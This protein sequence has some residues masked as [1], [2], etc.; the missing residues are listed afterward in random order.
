M[1]KIHDNINKQPLL[2]NISAVILKE[3]NINTTPT[4]TRTFYPNQTGFDTYLCNSWLAEHHVNI[5]WRLHLSRQMLT[6]K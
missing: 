4:V 5:A 3:T 2:F 1:K 6:V